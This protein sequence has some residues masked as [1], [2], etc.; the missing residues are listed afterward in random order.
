[1][2]DSDSITAWI[3][4]VRQGDALAAERLWNAY[5]QKL[6]AVARQRMDGARNVVTDEEDVALSAFHSFCQAARKGRFEQLTNRESLWPLLVSITANK[7]VDA[8]RR[9]NRKKRG[10]TGSADAD[11]DTPGRRVELADGV[12][13][14]DRGPTPE[15]A[16]QLSEHFHLLLT[17]LD[18]TGDPQMRR[19]ALLKFEGA[20]TT[21]IASELNCA[22]RT[23]E[24]KL[25]I[26][27]R[28]L[29]DFQDAA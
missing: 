22:R 13:F 23:V 17:K 14:L 9:E 1:M 15:F 10:G 20:S 26:V 5:F 16:A 28:V 24:R 18:E 12:E 4:G 25:Q 2:S 6:T 27:R 3:D 29:T 7:S 19:V 11:S 8:V 21:E